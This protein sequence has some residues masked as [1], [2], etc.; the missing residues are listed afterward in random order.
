[1]SKDQYIN[2]LIVMIIS[3]IETPSAININN[4]AYWIQIGLA[5]AT[6]M[7]L[8]VW[9]KLDSK[10][11][12]DIESIFVEALGSVLVCFVGW[13]VYYEYKLT[14]NLMLYMVGLAFISSHAIRAGNKIDMSS[15]IEAILNKL[16][17]KKQSN[18]SDIK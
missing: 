8:K 6:G 11:K 10:Q 2:G 5:V 4:P 7:A 12:L 14:Y 15:I 18:D 16:G 9:V 17:F 3:G 1:M 13:I